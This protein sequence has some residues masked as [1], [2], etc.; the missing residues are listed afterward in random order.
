MKSKQLNKTEREYFNLINKNLP[1]FKDIGDNVDSELLHVAI[2]GGAAKNIMRVCAF[3]FDEDEEMMY[4]RLHWALGQYQF[5]YEQTKVRFPEIALKLNTGWVVMLH[6]DFTLR[7]V[8]NIKHDIQ[9]WMD[10]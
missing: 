2:A 3:T 4:Q 10:V 6:R 7:R 8:F 1:A 5:V 9:S